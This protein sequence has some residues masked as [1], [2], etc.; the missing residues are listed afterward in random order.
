MKSNFQ[1][2]GKVSTIIMGTSP[3][4]STYNNNGQ[5]VPLL[6][7]PTEFGPDHPNCTLYTTDPKQECES[8]DLIFC[9]RGSTT[10][11]MNWA[12]KKYALGRGVCSI[13]GN[14]REDTIFISYAL[15][16]YL[17]NLL[18]FAAGST[19]PNLTKDAL[20]EFK[21]PYPNNRSKIV[22]QIS[23]YDDLIENNRRRIKLLEAAARMLYKEWFVRLRF[24]G[25]EHV[26]VVD[27]V[28]E[29]WERKTAYEVMEVLSGG[30]P[31]T[32]VQDFWDGD[33]PFYT[34]KDSV[35]Y[36]YVNKTEKTLTEGGLR[37]CN[38][39][40]YPR[41]TVFI[42]ARG[43]V[44][45]IN[46]AQTAMAM[47]QSCYA[48]V[49][50]PPL[51]QYFLYF[52]LVEGV[53]QFRSRAVGAVFDAIIRDTFKLIPFIVP[54]EKLIQAFTDHI[55][56]ILQQINLLSIETEKLVQARDLLLPKLMNGEINV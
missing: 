48:L 16:I 6:N 49:A 1:E 34:P 41:D 44:G 19:F 21:I 52:A 23:A 26:K 4:G 2:L 9:V 27:G 53:E 55:S 50:K 47:N 29:G 36:A 40:L 17:K 56:P 42:T 33:I 11:R 30:T 46:L 51:N 8:N 3:K 37:N 38:S 32:N 35:D 12:D 13:R 7:G 18:Q 39:K 43:T 45:K 28:P 15:K 24:P 25:H 22:D 14:T 5:G 10:G 54:D 20:N 31:K